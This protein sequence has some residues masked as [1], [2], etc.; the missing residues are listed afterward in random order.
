MQKTYSLG[1]QGLPFEVQS[2]KHFVMRRPHSAIDRI[3]DQ[4]MA[5]RFHVDPDLMR[6]TGFQTAFDQR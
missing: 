4:R 2:G 1:V 3:A 6:A 5:Q